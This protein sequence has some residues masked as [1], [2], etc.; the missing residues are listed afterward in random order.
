MK[1]LPREIEEKYTGVPVIIY[2]YMKDKD[3]SP[4]RGETT[5]KNETPTPESPEK[6]SL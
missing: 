3:L 1:T 2:Y 4:R 6:Q 5:F